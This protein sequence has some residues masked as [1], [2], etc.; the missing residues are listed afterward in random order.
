VASSN[1]SSSG[2][3]AF[4]PEGSEY[5]A[6]VR[7]RPQ[8]QGVEMRWISRSEG[9]RRDKDKAPKAKAYRDGDV[10][11]MYNVMLWCMIRANKVREGLP[12]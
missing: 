6:S 8:A 5:I 3:R 10:K 4:V 9:G 1:T 7:R 2:S 11:Y 12:R